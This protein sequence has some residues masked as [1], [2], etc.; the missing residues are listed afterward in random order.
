M[1]DSA[2]WHIPTTLDAAETII[3]IFNARHPRW[4]KT[5][6]VFALIGVSDGNGGIVWVLTPCLR[7]RASKHGYTRAQAAAQNALLGAGKFVVLYPRRERGVL[8][9][10]RIVA[11]DHVPAL[12][13][14][15][16]RKEHICFG[17]G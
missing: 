13:F 16:G 15:D 4:R 6:T 7:V 5:R 10:A 1:D 12:L 2:S 8:T 11:V 9:G 17:P 14:P 3:H